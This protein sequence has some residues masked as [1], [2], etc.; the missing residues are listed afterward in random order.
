MTKKQKVD[1]GV[2]NEIAKLKLALKAG[3]TKVSASTPAERAATLVLLRT[4]A[5]RMRPDRR[6]EKVAGVR[7]NR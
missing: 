1:P 4:G 3:P 6:L 5:V 2:T 7:D